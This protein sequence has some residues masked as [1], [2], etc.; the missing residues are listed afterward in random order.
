M[1]DTCI[2]DRCKGYDDPD[3]YD[4]SCKK[5]YVDDYLSPSDSDINFCPNCGKKIEVKNGE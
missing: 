2:W 4:T 3:S 5:E 1:I